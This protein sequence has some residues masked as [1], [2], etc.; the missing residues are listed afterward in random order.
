MQKFDKKNVTV[1]PWH[2]FVSFV[3]AERCEDTTSW[4]GIH[5]NVKVKTDEVSRWWKAPKLWQQILP[6]KCPISDELPVFCATCVAC[7]AETVQNHPVLCVKHRCTVCDRNQATSAVY[8]YLHFA[9][10]R[11]QMTISTNMRWTLHCG[12]CQIACAN[13]A[14]MF[15]THRMAILN[16]LCKRPDVVGGAFWSFARKDAVLA[17]A[18]S[19]WCLPICPSDRAVSSDLNI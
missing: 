14:A 11:Q 6:E 9:W 15:H 18:L 4:L 7:C 2:V 12:R 19:P 3:C 13:C 10:N 17:K 8:Y 1:E 16:S 5:L